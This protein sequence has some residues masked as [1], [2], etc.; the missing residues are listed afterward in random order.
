MYGLTTTFSHAFSIC[1]PPSICPSSMPFHLRQMYAKA[2]GKKFV[3]SKIAKA[4]GGKKA[5]APMPAA[6]TV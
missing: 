2:L 5:A 6:V 1:S 3:K 4:T